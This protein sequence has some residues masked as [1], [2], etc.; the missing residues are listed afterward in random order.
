VSL[1][2]LDRP[3]PTVAQPLGP[4]A[5]A[6]LLP[7]RFPFLLLDRI[8][9]VVPMQRATGRKTV[10]A[11]EP[12]LLPPEAQE[13]PMAFVVESLGQLAIALFNLSSKGGAPPKV[14][15][16]NVSGV[17]FHR[18]IPLGCSLDLEVRIERVIAHQFIASGAARIGDDP[19]MT[20]DSLICK[21]ITEGDAA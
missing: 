20:M 6:Q 21:I 10:G 18:P 13:W 11:L 12:F 8:D 14:L 16:G 1:A 3:A 7:Q 2:I 9:S 19:V 5:V 17:T 15:L 4:A